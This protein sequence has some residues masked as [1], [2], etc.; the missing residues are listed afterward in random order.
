MSRIALAK[1]AI[2]KGVTGNWPGYKT[3][4]G[5]VSSFLRHPA[6]LAI[7]GA[8]VGGVAS[9]LTGGSF[10]SGAFYGAMGGAAGYGIRAYRPQIGRFVSGSPVGG[11]SMRG[12]LRWATRGRRRAVLGGAALGGAIFGN[13]SNKHTRGMNSARG[14]HI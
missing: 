13:R 12:M 8:G 4:A 2:V 6:G 7:A 3:V 10:T 1:E 9:M 14:A 11:D 5:K